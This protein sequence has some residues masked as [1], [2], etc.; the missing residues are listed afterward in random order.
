MIE[1]AYAKLNLTLEI[2]GKKEGYHLLES[3][4]IP[5]D[6]H[7]TLS[8]E[9]SAQDEVIGNIEIKDNN[10]YQAIEL[11]KKTYNIQESVKVTLEKNIPIGYGLG[12]SS[13]NISATLR[14][15]NRLFEVNDSLKNLEILANK[16]G[17]D[18]LFCLYQKRAFITGRGEFIQFANKSSNDQYLL[19]IP[20]TNLLTRDVFKNYQK[21]NHYIGFKEVFEK[22]DYNFIDT[23]SKND[24][25][26][27]ALNLNKDLKEIYN[28]LKKDGY[29]P[30]LTGSGPTLFIK[31]P[32]TEDIK[33][34][35]EKTNK[36]V[37]LILT[38][39]I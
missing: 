21:S 30:S 29:N 7:D 33:L 8:F 34:I 25:L 28:Q 12:G 39:E 4:V 5:I 10:I 26:N 22:A 14:G 23:Y 11:F 27:V 3:I 9:K 24:L 32:S 19:I 36:N 2:V 13:A 15:L 6:L 1:K 35:R 18:T 37:L 38:K 31:N 20:P 16:L 17:S